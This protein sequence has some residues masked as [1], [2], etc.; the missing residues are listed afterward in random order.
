MEVISTWQK[1][2]ASTGVPILSHVAC[3]LGNQLISSVTHCSPAPD[4]NI[5]A[6][7]GIINETANS[8]PLQGI[9]KDLLPFP[10]WILFFRNHK[11]SINC[12][13]TEYRMHKYHWQSI[14]LKRAQIDS[15]V[16]VVLPAVSICALLFTTQGE[17]R[18]L[19]FLEWK[20]TNALVDL[21]SHMPLLQHGRCMAWG[22]GRPRFLWGSFWRKALP[23]TSLLCV[24]S[25]CSGK[26]TNT[27]WASTAITI[28]KHD[29][30]ASVSSQ[31]WLHQEL[32]RHRRWL[33]PFLKSKLSLCGNRTRSSVSKDW[34]KGWFNYI[35]QTTLSLWMNTFLGQKVT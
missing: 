9:R 16:P 10:F 24:T 13:A 22:Q 4:S 8:A 34:K 19:T 25:S 1:K 12:P 2:E 5:S 30:Q 14:P 31:T 17:G 15:W 35:P 3:C 32:C 33:C 6:R 18:S 28:I 11:S 23:F 26:H 20:H 27:Y 21:F 29:N 7:F